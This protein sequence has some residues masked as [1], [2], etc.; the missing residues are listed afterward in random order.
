MV[1]PVLG[2]G[3]LSYQVEDECDLY[4]LVC[5]CALGG[6]SELLFRTIVVKVCVLYPDIFE[7]TLRYCKVIFC[8]N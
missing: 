6:E 3:D 2:C 1:T 7:E 4:V 5:A 8:G